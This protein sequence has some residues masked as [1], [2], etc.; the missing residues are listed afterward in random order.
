MIFLNS[1]GNNITDQIMAPLA[2]S[3]SKCRGLRELNLSSNALSSKGF[4]YLMSVGLFW[5]D[6][7]SVGLFW[8]SL[9][10]FGD[11]IGI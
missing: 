6:L 8:D 1:T 3:L 7:M 5:V 11:L 2:Q 10:F 9:G 4:R